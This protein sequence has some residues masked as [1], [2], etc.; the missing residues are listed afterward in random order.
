MSD[1]VPLLLL[2][3][4]F[5][6]CSCPVPVPVLLLLSSHPQLA[7]MAEL[8]SENYKGR[9]YLKKVKEEQTR[10][11]ELA[12]IT[13]KDADTLAMSRCVHK[14][15]DGLLRSASGKARLLA[16]QKMKQFEGLCNVH[17]NPMP[18]EKFPVT[19]DDLQGFWDMVSMQVE[20]V[21]DMFANIKKLKSNG[22]K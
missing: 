13:E 8:P 1:P 15:I 16:T 5:C 7:A 10:L 2:L 17:L 6:S 21:D 22:W 14:D 9:F 19:L 11:L 18:D 3:S 4:C 12:A 20:Q